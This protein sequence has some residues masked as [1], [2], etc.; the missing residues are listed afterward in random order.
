M[1]MQDTSNT[2]GGHFSPRNPIFTCKGRK[3]PKAHWWDRVGSPGLPLHLCVCVCI[4]TGMD[5]LH[6]QGRYP[7]DGLSDFAATRRRALAPL[8]TPAHA[9][10]TSGVMAARAFRRVPQADAGKLMMNLIGGGLCPFP[11][12]EHAAFRELLFTL[13]PQWQLIARPKYSQS[14]FGQRRL[15]RHIS[16]RSLWMQRTH[17]ELF[18]ESYRRR[19]KT[20]ASTSECQSVLWQWGAQSSAWASDAYLFVWY[21]C[22][23]VTIST[24]CHTFSTYLCVTFANVS[25]CLLPVNRPSPADTAFLISCCTETKP[26]AAALRG[27]ER[28]KKKK[29]ALQNPVDASFVWFVTPSFVGLRA[30]KWP[31]KVLQVSCM[32]VYSRVPTLKFPVLW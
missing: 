22:E 29:D 26:A 19:A 28:K 4:C 3:A 31:S 15:Q 25:L 10:G 14:P 2:L 6:S 32:A 11:L 17:A 21:S 27:K 30:L 9:N 18:R 12:A 16:V 23:T 7:A 24:L 5:T 13:N 1:A 8:E 20:S